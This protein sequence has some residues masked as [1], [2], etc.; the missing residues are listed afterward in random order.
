MTAAAMG[1]WGKPRLSHHTIYAV[2]EAP[3]QAMRNHGTFGGMLR[4]VNEGAR[5]GGPTVTQW[6]NAIAPS[7]IGGNGALGSWGFW[8][9]GMPTLYNKRQFI[10]ATGTY[11]GRMGWVTIPGPQTILQE[12]SILSLQ[13]GGA[14]VSRPPYRGPMYVS[15]VTVGA[16]GMGAHMVDFYHRRLYPRG[17]LSQSLG[18]PNPF[19]S[20]NMP[21]SLTVG[22]PNLHQQV[23]FDATTYGN[24]WVSLR[25]RG[26]TAQ[27]FES[28]LS[29]YDYQNFKHRMRVRRAEKPVVRLTLAPSGLESAWVGTPGVRPG[30][31]FIR[32]DGNSDQFRKG[33]F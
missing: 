9:V 17:F 31:H 3:E 28:F 12:D 33:A 27:G 10:Q 13:W 30:V 5:I 1:S 29:E 19:A 15:S 16:G 22:P 2:L 23:G 14:T 25:V 8:G 11:M 21:N 7:G 20:A 18:G 4:P 26:V 6:N 32:P 24:A